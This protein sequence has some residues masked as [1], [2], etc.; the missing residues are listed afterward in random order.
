MDYYGFPYRNFCSNKTRFVSTADF[1]TLR[2]DDLSTKYQKQ[3]LR[4]QG[5][6]MEKIY[7]PFRIDYL[8]V[9]LLYSFKHIT[10]SMHII[11]I[12]QSRDHLPFMGS[13][14][15]KQRPPASKG[16]ESSL[17]RDSFVWEW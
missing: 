10:P 9:C 2:F 8:K 5:V 14:D 12:D 13:N 11:D 3:S 6:S 17:S 1:A 7:A 15:S 16:F 4:E